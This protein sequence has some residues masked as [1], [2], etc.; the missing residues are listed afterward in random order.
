[1]SFIFRNLKIVESD[2]CQTLLSSKTVDSK[3]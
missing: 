3:K 1:M 2:K